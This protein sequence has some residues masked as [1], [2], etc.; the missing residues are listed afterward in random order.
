MDTRTEQLL[1]ETSD[2]IYSRVWW[3]ITIG[4][5]WGLPVVLSE[6]ARPFARQKTLVRQGLSQTLKSKH[7]SGDAVDIDMQGFH[8][9]DVPV[10]VWQ[11][12][13]ELGEALG[14]RWG[15]RWKSLRDLRHF[16]VL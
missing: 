4:R 16:E 14:L 6:V 10:E 2:R 8:P 3:L 9:D 13:G 7:L 1:T 12:M 5:R 15:G 11:W